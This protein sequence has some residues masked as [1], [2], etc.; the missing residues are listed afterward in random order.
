LQQTAGMAKT[1][2]ALV[3]SLRDQLENLAAFGPQNLPVVSLYLNLAADQ[4]GRDS[5]DAFLRKAFA[6]RQKAFPDNTP[7]RA[8]FDADAA[9]IRDYLD[10][11]VNRSAN[12]VAIFACNGA[13]GFFEAIQLQVPVEDH[14]LFI[15][16]VP[17][18]YPLAKLVDQ[19]PRYAAV[20]LDTHQ[21][22][23]V[24]FSLGEVEHR[25]QVTGVKTRRSSMGGWSQARYQRR[26]ENF[27]LHH[28]KEVVETLDKVATA[29][30]VPHIVIAGDEVVVPLVKE[31]LPQRLIDKLVD[32]VHLEQDV[33]EDD[34]L[35]ATLETL[36]QKDAESD[37]EAAQEVIGAWQANG[38]GTV[39]PEAVLQALTLGQVDE[40]LITGTPEGLKPVQNMP[41]DSVARDVTAETS[42]PSGP[43]DAD[44]LKLAG[45]LVLRAQ[46][47]G[48]RVKFIEDAELLK[49]IGGVAARLRF[50]V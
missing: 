44:Q 22:R 18:L 39:G 46:Q 8:S 21:A 2:P 25:E 33:A 49:D 23:I 35:R 42:A 27:H 28:V 41:A 45:E 11:E 29:E 47:T 15:G 48:A 36:Q 7:A 20:V 12:A 13:D 4:H 16:S 34:L 50:R 43:G 30:N 10:A 38:L 1:S 9:R 5:Y 3:T 6:D 26:A 40:L 19:F 24:V 37:I 31:Q 17:H 32:I 14:W